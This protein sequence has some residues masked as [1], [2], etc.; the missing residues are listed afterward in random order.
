MVLTANSDELVYDVIKKI[1]C[2]KF[3]DLLKIVGEFDLFD[4]ELGL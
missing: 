2:N 3:C 1:R 4:F